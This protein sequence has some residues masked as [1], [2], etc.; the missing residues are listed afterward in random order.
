MGPL[1]GRASGA[2]RDGLDI[3]RRVARGRRNSRYGWI[4][5]YEYW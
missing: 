3:A 1:A 5:K 4:A 2:M